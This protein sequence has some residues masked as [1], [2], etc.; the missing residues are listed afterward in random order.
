MLIFLPVYNENY[1]VDKK[2]KTKN[3]CYSFLMLD[4]KDNNIN[5]GEKDIE[6]TIIICSPKKML[7]NNNKDKATYILSHVFGSNNDA[8]YFINRL[9]S[10]SCFVTTSGGGKYVSVIYCPEVKGII[11]RKSRPVR[12][13][14]LNENFGTENNGISEETLR[15]GPAYLNK[16]NNRKKTTKEQSLTMNPLVI[17]MDNSSFKSLAYLIRQTTPQNRRLRYNILYISNEKYSEKTFK[18]INF[19]KHVNKGSVKSIKYL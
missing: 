17:A 1:I 19:L 6:S 8:K 18:I 12:I 13:I 15:K 9:C 3:D 10:T 4:N 2:K 14:S 7:A 11:N 16:I 5:N